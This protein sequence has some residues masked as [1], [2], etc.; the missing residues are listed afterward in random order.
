MIVVF[1]IE[2]VPVLSELQSKVV[3]HQSKTVA[4]VLAVTRRQEDGKVAKLELTL[5]LD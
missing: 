4:S 2:R 3:V 5:N 1:Q